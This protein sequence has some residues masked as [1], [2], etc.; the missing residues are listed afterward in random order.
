MNLQCKNLSGELQDQ[1]SSCLKV[2]DVRC[3]TL[4]AKMKFQ[5]KASKANRTT[6]ANMDTKRKKE[7]GQQTQHSRFGVGI[8]F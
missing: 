2:A 6:N 7:K 3:L 8:S 5:T 1:W 4:Y